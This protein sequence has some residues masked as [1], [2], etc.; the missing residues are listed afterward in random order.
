MYNKKMAIKFLTINIL[1]GGMVWDNLV[2]FIESEKPDILAIQEVYNGQGSH[3]EKRFRTMNEF[4]NLFSSFLPHNAFG[5]TV[6]DKSVNATWGNAVFS[7]FPITN[8]RTVFFDLPFSEYTFDKDTDPRLVPEGMLEAEIRVNDSKLNVYSWHGVWDNHGQDTENRYIM[9][10]KIIEAIRGKEN[11]ILAGDTNINPDTQTIADITHELGLKSVFGT[12]LQS[13][14]NMERKE[15]PGNYA[16]SPVDMV[17]V[18][19]ELQIIEK[20]MPLVDVSDHYPLKVLL[21]V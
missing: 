2:H 19:P 5:A 12:S 9:G 20:E 17:F 4:E 21:E 7:R 15:Q 8:Y 14:F 16:H 3:L 6:L 11:V 13:T 18:S 10:R 1:F